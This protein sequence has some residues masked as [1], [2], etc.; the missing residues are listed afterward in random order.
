M[1]HVVSDAGLIGH[2]IRDIQAGSKHAASRAQ[3]AIEELGDTSSIQDRSIEYAADVG[4]PTAGIHPKGLEYL[5]K[6]F[7]EARSLLGAWIRADEQE[8][9]NDQ[10]ND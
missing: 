7:D 6:Q 8:G 3:R 1:H 10:R 4:K 5:D 2:A 9:S